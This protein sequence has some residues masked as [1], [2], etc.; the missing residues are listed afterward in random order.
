MKLIICL[1][2]LGTL[3]TSC[4]VSHHDRLVGTWTSVELGGTDV[5]TKIVAIQYAFAADGTITITGNVKGQ[6]VSIQNGTYSVSNNVLRVIIE[7]LHPQNA[8]YTL[9]DEVLTI[10]DSKIDAWVKF[11]QGMAEQI[12][13][14][15]PSE[16][17]PSE[18][19]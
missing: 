8:E 13:A 4:A 15:L 5:G 9:V 18:G 17:A 10:H 11:K 12:A 6:E 3:L 2:L 14:P 19:R 7:G 1:V 16:G